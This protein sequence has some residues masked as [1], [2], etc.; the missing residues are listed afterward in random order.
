VDRQGFGKPKDYGPRAPA[1]VTALL[2]LLNAARARGY[3][4]IDEV[5]ALGIA[6]MAAPVTRSSEAIGVISI[7]GPRS[8]PTPARVQELAPALL[9]ATATAELGPISRAA[10]L[11]GRPPLGKA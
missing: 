5:F 4:V 1:T 11:F 7:A 8:R 10:T 3:A 9:S 6:A 2:E